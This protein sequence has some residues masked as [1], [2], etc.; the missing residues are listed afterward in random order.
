MG[1]RTLDWLF[2]INYWSATDQTEQRIM[3]HGINAMTRKSKV[4]DWPVVTFSWNNG[5]IVD[6]KCYFYLFNHYFRVLVTYVS[7]E[8]LTSNNILTTYILQ[9]DF[10][11]CV[12]T[13]CSLC[14]LCRFLWVLFYFLTI[15][16]F[17]CLKTNEAQNMYDFF[18]NW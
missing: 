9:T 18:L 10:V 16:A 2:A 1:T 5:D 7:W 8:C 14:R 12:L 3:K 13:I 11:F 17:F 15:A 6:I 4:T